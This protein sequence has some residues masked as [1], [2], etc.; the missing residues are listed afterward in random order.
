MRLL[1]VD[2]SLEKKVWE[3]IEQPYYFRISAAIT[4]R[5]DGVDIFSYYIT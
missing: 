5:I 3:G 1:H 4:E 2:C